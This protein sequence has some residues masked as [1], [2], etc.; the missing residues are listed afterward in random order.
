MGVEVEEFNAFKF[1]YENSQS[2][3]FAFFLYVSDKSS[4]QVIRYI[5]HSKKFIDEVARKAGVFTY[6][7]VDLK[8]NSQGRVNPSGDIARLFGIPLRELPG[9]LVFTKADHLKECPGVVFPFD[10]ILFT[11]GREVELENRFKEMYDKIS[12]C[13]LRHAD[14]YKVIECLERQRSRWDRDDDERPGSDYVR[15]QIIR[16]GLPDLP[17]RL[18][19]EIEK[20]LLNGW[21]GHWTQQGEGL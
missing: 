9:I 1:H 20:R 8:S 14:P 4:L 11:E 6:Y 21:I 17:S 12:Q 19:S 16:S 3:V 18:I 10:P 2:E 5:S 13:K 15:R 7:F